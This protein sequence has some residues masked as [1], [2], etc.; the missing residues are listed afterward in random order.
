MSCCRWTR[1]NNSNGNDGITAFQW[2]GK[3]ERIQRRR[4]IHV[5]SVGSFS[6]QQTLSDQFNLQD[7]TMRLSQEVI[8]INR[9]RIPS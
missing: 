3:A 7:L 5:S 2:A 8:T 1:A 6:G 4:V 9:F